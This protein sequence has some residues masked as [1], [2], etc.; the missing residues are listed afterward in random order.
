MVTMK[1]ASVEENL[2]QDQ[3]DLLL[4]FVN[5]MQDK[6]IKVLELLNTHSSVSNYNSAT[7]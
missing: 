4:K 5:L 3:I 7:C 1:S 6:M 2:T